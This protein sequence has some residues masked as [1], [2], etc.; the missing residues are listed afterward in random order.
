MT[1]SG[2]K[3]QPRKRRN[4]LTANN[5]V[6]RGQGMDEEA[7]AAYERYVLASVKYATQGQEAIQAEQ[8]KAIESMIPGTLHYYHLFFLDLSKRKDFD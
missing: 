1:D 5:L 2:I 8:K 3:N 7:V 4:W 6:A